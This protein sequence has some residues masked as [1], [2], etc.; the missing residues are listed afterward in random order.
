MKKLAIFASGGGSNAENI[1]RLFHQG[2]QIR[3][4][5]VLANKENAGVF[6]R[7]EPLGVPVVYVPNSVWANEPEKVLQILEPY[8]VDM[9]I[10]AGF[11][12]AVHPK[13]IAAYK[14]RILNIHPA[15]L[16]AYGGKGMYGHHVHEAVLAAG[17]KK[18]GVTVHYVSEEIDGGEILMQQEVEVLEGDTPDTLAERVH[19]AEYSL[20]PRA[21]VAALQ[22]INTPAPP[23]PGAP[24][25]PEPAPAPEVPAPAPEV[26]G[27]PAVPPRPAAP[28][29]PSA[30]EEWAEVLQVRY[31]DREA[32][33]A[34]ARVQPAAVPPPSPAAPAAPPVTPD[35]AA[36]EQPK[37][38]LWAAILVTILCCTP[39]GI[40]AIVYSAS[41]GSRNSAGDRQGAERAS[42]MAQ[43]WIIASFVVGVLW[44]T[45]ISP[46]YF[47]S[48]LLF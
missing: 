24:P 31:S 13:I 34:A 47:F 48:S 23:V 9:V 11:L 22:R 30:D 44:S 14:N 12:R 32:K 35:T 17:E 8:G 27:A 4:S 38:Y 19:Q 3:V 15:L 39:L 21:I 42:R 16:P 33:E 25:V 37:S 36:K 41:V 43:T 29:P 1:T 45:I 10:L 18:S 20:F 26:P 46:I 6:S 40:V 2:N 28:A 7:M 5:V